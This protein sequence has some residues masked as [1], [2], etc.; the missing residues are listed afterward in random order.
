MPVTGL[1]FAVVTGLCG[2]TAVS[3]TI[4]DDDPALR[5]IDVVE[6]PG[7][8]I[9]R[10]IILTN[11]AGETV[12]LG[13]YFDGD[14]PALL[15]LAYYTCPM[16]CNLILNGLTAGA[17]QLSIL[18]G[19]D[20]RILVVSID[21][22]ETFD[23]AAAKKQNYLG[24][25]GRPETAAGWT[26]FVAAEDQSRRLAD[27][28]GFKYYYDEDLKQYAHA[29]L[30]TV[31][32]GSGVISRYL[33]GIEFKS[34]DLKFALMEASEGAIGSTFDRILLYCYHYDPDAGGYTVLAA[35]VMKLGG[36]VTLFL[37]AGLLG[38]FWIREIRRRATRPESMQKVMGPR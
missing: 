2:E 6:H 14:R 8:S 11:D 30:V 22:T 34:R 24:Q 36:A 16:L 20:Y 38:F 37:L 33:Y 17:G 1:I 9:P 15:V 29:A 3:Q 28:I 19:K 23:L 18:P 4:R 10:D 35:N 12:T 21:P 5:G 7:D 32:T 13:D 31:V 26:F 25:F 27:A